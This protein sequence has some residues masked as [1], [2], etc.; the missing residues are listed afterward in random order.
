MCADVVTGA[1]S[2]LQVAVAMGDSV[3]VAD[4]QLEADRKGPE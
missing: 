4:R 2:N 3:N 1:C